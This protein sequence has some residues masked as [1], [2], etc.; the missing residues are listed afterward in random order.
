MCIRYDTGAESELEQKRYGVETD[1]IVVNGARIMCNCADRNGKPNYIKVL[2]G[3]GIMENGNNCAHDGSCIPIENIQPFSSCFSPNTKQALTALLPSAEGEAKKRYQD[4]LTIIN[5]NETTG[6]YM[7]VPCA[8]PLLDRWFDADEKKTV[9]DIMMLETE[10]KQKI[11]KLQES[12]DESLQNTNDDLNLAFLFLLFFEDAGEDRLDVFYMGTDLLKVKERLPELCSNISRTIQTKSVIGEDGFKEIAGQLEQIKLDLT[13]IK[14]CWNKVH[15]S[16]EY[17]KNYE[18][19][20]TLLGQYIKETDEII[21]KIN[22]WEEKEYHLIT[23]KSF[24]VCRCGGIIS[25][26]DSGQEFEKTV[27][28]LMAS[29]L[30]MITEFREH[31]QKGMTDY[32]VKDW[33]YVDHEWSSYQ[34]AAEGLGVFEKMMLESGETETAMETCI[35]MELICHSYNDEMSKTVM[36]ALALLSLEC[37]V[38]AFLLAFYSIATMDESERGVADGISADISALESIGETAKNN[39]FEGLLTQE[40]AGAVVQ[41]NNVYTVVT[42]IINFF[43]ISYDTWIENVRITVFTDSH[44]HVYERKLNR[45]GSI[46]GK[47]YVQMWTKSDYISGDL[48]RGLKW[49]EDPGVYMKRIVHKG[50]NAKGEGTEALNKNH[51]HNTAEEH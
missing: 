20:D 5:N 48:G 35:Y 36:S 44:A 3:H 21:Q 17:L 19:Y 4:A 14:K 42:S 41:L 49:K 18:E 45:T 27:D 22:N 23:T 31:C 12:L 29:V 25:F 37:N 15:D 39:E 47:M 38:L 8:L 50:D 13:E 34:A 51:V 10:I 28:Q 7:P 2:D 11:K 24:L 33:D 40:G 30:V 46:L 26:V 1:E 6:R 32:C 16:C 9:T 43:Y